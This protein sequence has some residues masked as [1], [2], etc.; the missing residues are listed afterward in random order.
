M[1]RLPPRAGGEIG[2]RT[3]LKMWRPLVM[4][5]RVSPRPLLLRGKRHGTT[6]Q[7]LGIAPASGTK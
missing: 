5:V 6:A 2:R 1:K 7:K 4:R 3:T